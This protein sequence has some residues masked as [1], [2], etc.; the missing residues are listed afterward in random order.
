MAD[1]K[2]KK[3]FRHSSTFYRRVNRNLISSLASES[4]NDLSLENKEENNETYIQDSAKIK[5]NPEKFCLENPL[6]DIQGLTQ[7]FLL[8]KQLKEWA[9]TYQITH[10]SFNQLLQIL[11]NTAGLSTL[12]IDSRTLLS[13]PK[14]VNI[15]NMGNGKFWYNGI[16]KH[17]VNILSDIT[18]ETTVSLIL[19]IDGLPPFKNSSLE[20]WPILG[21]IENFPHLNPFV[22]AIFS[23]FTKPPLAD[24]FHD[25]VFEMDELLKNGMMINNYTIKVKI[26]YFV[27]DTPARSFIKGKYRQTLFRKNNNKGLL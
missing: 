21:K 2:K 11:R 17:L 13:T 26:K 1:S 10:T 15:K 23:G 24:F 25:F 18:E 12:P 5:D 7:N 27:C 22:I 8:E 14:Y 9:L 3:I 6:D 20:L 4:K 16:Q 19:N